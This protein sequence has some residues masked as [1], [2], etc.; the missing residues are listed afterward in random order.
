MKAL[1]R[2]REDG[3]GPGEQIRI[4][5]FVELHVPGKRRSGRINGPEFS[6]QDFLVFRW[7]GGHRW[8]PT[9][10][11]LNRAETKNG[12]VATRGRRRGGGNWWEGQGDHSLYKKSTCKIPSHSDPG[13]GEVGG[14]WKG[15]W[16]MKKAINT[17]F[18][19][20]P[21]SL[22]QRT[23]DR[24]AASLLSHSLSHTLSLSLSF[25]VPPAQTDSHSNQTSKASHL[26]HSVLLTHTHSLSHSL[27]LSRTLPLPLWNFLYLAWP[28]KSWPQKWK[29]DWSTARATDQS[30]SR[31]GL[32]RKISIGRSFPKKIKNSP[33]S[34]G[35]NC[36]HF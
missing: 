3:F 24:R 22:G 19:L 10:G 14:W 30:P 12:V 11:S 4:F 8:P 32:D 36:A 23:R 34:F 21:R 15:A 29:P 35:F 26:Y 28:S 16:T 20:S 27:T 7:P 13:T 17:H 33:E 5:W 1:P 25:R 31:S 6:E 2:S 18:W 9:P